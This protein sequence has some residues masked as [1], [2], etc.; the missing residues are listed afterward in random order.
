MLEFVTGRILRDHRD[1]LE[2]VLERDTGPLEKIKA[3]FARVH[4][5]EAVRMLT[6]AGRDFQ[7]GGDLGAEDESELSKHFDQP[8]FVHRFPRAL[9]PFYMAPDPEDER[10]SLSVDCLASE[11]YGEIVGGGQRVV[12]DDAVDSV[13]AVLHG[14]VVAE[15]AE[16]VADVGQAGRLHAAEDAATTAGDGLGAGGGL[17]RSFGHGLAGA[18]CFLAA[19]PLGARL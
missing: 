8:F 13:E 19:M 15:G 16:M 17:G 12:V 18:W 1:L 10:V 3:P 11:G 2:Q 14:D 4:Y 7:W 6:D 5:D 9:K